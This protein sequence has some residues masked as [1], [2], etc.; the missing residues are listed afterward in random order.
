MLFN[1]VR[2][3]ENRFVFKA[4]IKINKFE[5]KKLKKRGYK[6]INTIDRDFLINHGFTEDTGKEA[7]S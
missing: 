4:T 3:K 5:F 1:Q 2:N 6:P 7:L